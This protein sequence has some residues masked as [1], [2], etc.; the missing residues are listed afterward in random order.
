MT[1]PFPLPILFTAWT[2]KDGAGIAGEVIRRAKLMGAKTVA[3]Q[4]SQDTGGDP[5]STL[6]PQDVQYL[7]DAGLFV[8]GWD[9]VGSPAATQILLNGL[10]VDGWL[11]QVEGPGQRDALIAALQQGVG[12]GKP[13]ALVTTY[14]GLDTQPD[15][16]A[17]TAA[18]GAE[19]FTFVECYAADGPI[20]ADVSRMLSQGVV[21]GF[22]SDCLRGLVGCYRGETPSSYTGLDASNY[23]GLYLEENAS[24]DQLKAFAPYAAP[25]TPAPAPTPAPSTTADPAALNRQIDKLAHQWLDQ[26]T[27]PKLLSR[28]RCIDDIATSSDTGWV[29]VRQDVRDALDGKVEQLRTQLSDLQTQLAESQRQLTNVTAERD[30]FKGK[31]AAAKAA[32]S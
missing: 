5:G 25:A 23:G 12:K 14:G 15:K 16:Q 32:L 2:W 18:W 1:S 17:L 28:L 13:K 30:M 26:Q 11:P 22:R 3:V 29:A 21:Y 10:G 8:V 9:P 6:D 19:P 7:H 4:L 20:H 27:D 24:D 31:V